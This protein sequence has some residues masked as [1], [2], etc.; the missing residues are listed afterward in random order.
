M[1][2]KSSVINTQVFRVVTQ[3]HN[4]EDLNL[5]VYCRED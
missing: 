1:V 2:T 3:R 4:P 5:N